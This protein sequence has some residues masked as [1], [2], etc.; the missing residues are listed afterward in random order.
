LQFSSEIGTF[1][2]EHI[3]HE[4]QTVEQ[5]EDGSVIVSFETTQLPEVKRLVLGQ[6]RTVKILEPKELVDEIKEELATMKNFY[7]K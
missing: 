2:A 5:N 4:G 1:A 6:G 3:W 7:N